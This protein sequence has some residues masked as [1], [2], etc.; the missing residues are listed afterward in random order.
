M[1]IKTHIFELTNGKYKNLTELANVMGISVSQIYR[2]REGNRKINQKFIV[3]ALNAF[4]EYKLD[5]LFYLTPEEPTLPIIKA[6]CQNEYSL[7][8]YPNDGQYSVREEPVI[9]KES[10]LVDS[11]SNR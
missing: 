4:P 11:Y 8:E 3:G 7:P 2:V 9:S 5:Q 10:V 1:L 6:P